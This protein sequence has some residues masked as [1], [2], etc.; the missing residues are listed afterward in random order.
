M[1]ELPNGGQFIGRFVHVRKALML[2]IE[3]EFRTQECT[4]VHGQKAVNSLDT[5]DPNEFRSK[6]A[7]KITCP[8]P[9]SCGVGRRLHHRLWGIRHGVILRVQN[10]EFRVQSDTGRVGVWERQKAINRLR[11]GCRRA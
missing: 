11:A 1:N 3:T 5:I 10:A 6:K 4:K 8:P 2:L 7:E 9:I